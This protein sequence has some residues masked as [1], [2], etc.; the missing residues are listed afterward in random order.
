MDGDSRMAIWLADETD[1]AADLE[2]PW[3]EKRNFCSPFN[4]G[5]A[6]SDI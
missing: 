6:Y 5:F 2:C 3:T 4:Y 1:L